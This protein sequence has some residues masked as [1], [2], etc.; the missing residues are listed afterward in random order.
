MRQFLLAL[1]IL[2][3]SS[4]TW[5]QLP[6]N[7]ENNNHE[8]VETQLKIYPNPCKISKINI[9]FAI[10]EISEIR[11]VNIT[12]KEVL[13]K[14]YDFPVHKTQVLLH[15]IPNGIYLIQIKSPDNKLVVKKLM[16]SKP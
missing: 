12:G 13:R 9:D 8:K 11:L 14:K 7:D 2:L 16:V 6:W 5:S 10:K 1:F 4:P 3:F 15:N